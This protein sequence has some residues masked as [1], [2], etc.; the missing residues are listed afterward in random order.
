MKDDWPTLKEVR[1][2]AILLR[3]YSMKATETTGEDLWPGIDFG[4]FFGR[5]QKDGLSAWSQQD[6][7]MSDNMTPS[8]V[9]NRCYTQ[10]NHASSSNIDDGWLLFTNITQT[11]AAKLGRTPR[12]YADDLNPHLMSFLND[13]NHHENPPSVWSHDHGLLS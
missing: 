2:K 5:S 6:D 11:G 1:G 4:Y 12:Q 13:D 7:G 10:I 8:E 9:W 3:R